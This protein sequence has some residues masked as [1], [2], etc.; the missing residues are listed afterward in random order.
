MI[1]DARNIETL[2]CFQGPSKEPYNYQRQ[3]SR[4]VVIL[5]NC[6]VTQHLI[7]NQ[8]KPGFEP[9]SSSKTRRTTLCRFSHSSFVIGLKL[10]ELSDEGSGSDFIS[11]SFFFFFFSAFGSSF[12]FSFFSNFFCFFF[13]FFRLFF[14]FFLNFFFRFLSSSLE[15]VD[16]D[17]DELELELDDDDD[18]DD[19]D[20]RR[21]DFDFFFFFLVS[22]FFFLVLL[23]SSE[24]ELLELEADLFLGRDSLL[25]NELLLDKLLES[26]LKPFNLKEVKRTTQFLPTLYASLEDY[27]KEIF[28]VNQ[29]RELSCLTRS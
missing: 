29:L 9:V 23:P 15:L 11:F 6:S 5:K 4:I 28:K 19:D 13:S 12:C 27:S 20:D 17:D 3:K 21:L 24:L 18:D 8:E 16:D 22:L 1:E 25:E 26:I 14:S 2:H 10:R 7:A